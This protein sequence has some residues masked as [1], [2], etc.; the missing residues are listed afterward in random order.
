[1]R[2]VVM[3]QKI[4]VVGRMPEGDAALIGGMARKWGLELAD[5]PYS[6]VPDVLA[7]G[8]RPAG[9][10]SYVPCVYD[11]LSAAFGGRLAQFLED[12]PVCQCVGG[13]DIPLFVPD[14]PLCGVFN[15]PMSEPAAAS[16]MLS[17][18]RER[19]LIAARDALHRQLASNREQKDRLAAIAMAFCCENDIPSL[20]ALI[21]T[22]SREAVCADTGCIY[23][24]DRM[25][26][27]TLCDTL[28]FNLCQSD[29]FS[30]G[31]AGEPVIKINTDTMAGCAAYT[32]QFL[33]A[34]DIDKIRSD[35]PFRG[36]RSFVYPGYT[37]KSVLTMPLKNVEDEV[38]GVLQ[39]INKKPEKGMTLASPEDVRKRALPFTPDDVGVIR[40]LARYAA[41]S[42]ERI[43]LYKA[44]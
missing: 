23:T 17:I 21:L 19:G 20:L 39:L 35:A 16:V 5:E 24:R 27:D 25:V 38:V 41:V 37:C 11:D 10:I 36:D 2:I 22:V 14:I 9:V 6:R 7:D 4:I 26:D 40:F 28:R 34:D 30:G 44:G 31:V 1:M 3:G 12:V 18:T 32:G 42:L 43:S 15:S 29:S 13:G 8:E 33:E